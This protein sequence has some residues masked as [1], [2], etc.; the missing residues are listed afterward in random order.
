MK[1][2]TPIKR[3]QALVSFSRDHHFGLLLVWK[4]R[5]GLDNAVDP[6]RV[7][8]YVLY[9]FTEDLSWHFKEEEQNLFP[10]LPAGN[11]LRLQA[12]HEHVVIYDIINRLKSDK[13]N[14]DLLLQFANT[15]KS[16]IRFEERELFAFM[17]QTLPAEELEAIAIHDDSRARDADSRWEDVFW[18][19]DRAEQLK[20][21]K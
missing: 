5:Q 7:S 14:R 15:L 12:E 19:I 18:E 8:N 11:S 9:F 10:R 21:R 13:S 16:H 4:I 3:H 20:F 1:V 2:Q 6:E 17:Q